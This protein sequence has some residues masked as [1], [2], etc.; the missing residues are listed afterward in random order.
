[1]LSIS[2]SAQWNGR[3]DEWILDAIGK[4]AKGAQLLGSM[5]I[6]S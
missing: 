6:V 4:I 2:R 5:P 3:C 1:M